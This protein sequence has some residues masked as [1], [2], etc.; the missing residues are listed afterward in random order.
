MSAELCRREG[1]V[2]N[3]YYR[4]LSGQ[5][6]TGSTRCFNSPPRQ[7]A[8]GRWSRPYAFSGVGRLGERVARRPKCTDR[9]GVYTCCRRPFRHASASRRK[10]LGCAPGLCDADR[11][12]PLT[13][14]HA[15]VRV[16]FEFDPTADIVACRQGADSAGPAQPAP[17]CRGGDGIIAE[18]RAR[19]FNRAEKGRHDH[20]QRR[21]Y[22]LGNRR[23]RTRRRW[24]CSPSI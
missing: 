12:V 6:S 22:R 23:A 18:T 14:A 7:D 20:D 11:R 10:E 24:S 3:L 8:C 9:H 15:S 5:R 13:G 4:W 2:Q 1:I 17:Q 21:R 16:R 19:H